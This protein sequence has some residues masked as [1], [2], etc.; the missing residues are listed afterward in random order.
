[1]GSYGFVN[2]AAW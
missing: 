2:V 1:M